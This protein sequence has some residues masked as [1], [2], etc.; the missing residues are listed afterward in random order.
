MTLTCEEEC[1]FY[2][3]QP[4]FLDQHTFLHIPEIEMGLATGHYDV[5]VCRVKV[6]CKH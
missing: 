5:A 4:L 3:K 1:V 2:L 6:C